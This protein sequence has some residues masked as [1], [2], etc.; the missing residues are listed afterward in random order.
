M[1]LLPQDHRTHGR[2]NSTWSAVQWQQDQA[3]A[4]GTL[5]EGGVSSKCRDAEMCPAAILAAR[6]PVYRKGGAGASVTEED[7]GGHSR[8]EEKGSKEKV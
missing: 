7:R 2:A 3:P 8:Q 4:V 1:G 5:M 6:D